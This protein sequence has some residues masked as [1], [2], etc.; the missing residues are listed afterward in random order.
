MSDKIDMIFE[1]LSCGAS[2]DF[3]DLPDG[4]REDSIAKCPHCGATVG[5]YGD[6]MAEAEKVVQKA[7][8]D[9]MKDAFK[10][11]KGFEP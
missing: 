6:I 4:K 2:S 1:C 5:R 7:A 8:E 11:L 10:G 9:M 3:L